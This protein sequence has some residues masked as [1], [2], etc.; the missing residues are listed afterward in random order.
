VTR[1]TVHRSSATHNT[2]HRS[3]ATRSTVHQSSAADRI[4]SSNLLSD[5]VIFALSDDGEQSFTADVER[6]DERVQSRNAKRP[7]VGVDR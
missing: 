4:S 7:R 3:S 5:L 6:L 2:V 1:S